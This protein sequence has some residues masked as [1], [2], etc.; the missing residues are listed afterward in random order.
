MSVKTY[1]YQYKLKHAVNTLTSDFSRSANSILSLAAA[2]LR[3]VLDFISHDS[4]EAEKKQNEELA[5]IEEAEL[6][7]KMS[8][9]YFQK[10]ETEF[11]KWIGQNKNRPLD[12]YDPRDP[13]KVLAGRKGGKSK[14]SK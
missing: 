4:I 13:K 5:K 12:Y 10:T 14:T 8:D 1:N 7:Q 6:K 11:F 9:M 3:I 2:P